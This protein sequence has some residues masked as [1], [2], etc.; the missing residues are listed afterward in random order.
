MQ[1][2]SHVHKMKH[3]REMQPQIAVHILAQNGAAGGGRTAGRGEEDATEDGCGSDEVHR[4]LQANILQTTGGPH[5]ARS[6][7]YGTR[8]FFGVQWPPMRRVGGS[9][10]VAM[11]ESSMAVGLN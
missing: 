11:A 2:R 6:G 10:E 9:G 3:F 4:R 7:D 5:R 8:L 1:T